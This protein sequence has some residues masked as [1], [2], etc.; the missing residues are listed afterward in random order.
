MILAWSSSAWDDYLYWQQTDKKIMKR[1]NAL[2]KDT[3]RS[4]F[5]GLGAP[6]PLRHNWSGYWS[7][8]IDREHRLVY[9]VDETTLFI[10]QAR[11]HY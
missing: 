6:E 10:V 1:I 7:R 4:P 9:K 8:R 3:V 11:Y 2:V 5:E